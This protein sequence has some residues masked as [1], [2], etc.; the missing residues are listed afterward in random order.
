MVNIPRETTAPI[1]GKLLS[2]SSEVESAVVLVG[3]VVVVVEV[4]IVDVVV[5]TSFV[6]VKLSYLV[7]PFH[8]LNCI[9]YKILNAEIKTFRRSGEM[10]SPLL[11]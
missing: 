7:I 9:L 5:G 3:E 2:S 1:T 11:N 8:H 4:V 10:M 6:T